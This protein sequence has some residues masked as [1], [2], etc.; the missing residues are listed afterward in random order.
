MANIEKF[1]DACTWN[2]VIE[3]KRQIA[4][5]VDINASSRRSLR[6]SG[7]CAAMHNNHVYVML[8]Y[9][10]V[11]VVLSQSLCRKEREKLYII[12]DSTVF[13]FRV[14]EI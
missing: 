4:L 10:R 11:S 8:V 5:G 12:L 14:K 1:V 9:I 2:N 3:V 6:S 13:V 7:L